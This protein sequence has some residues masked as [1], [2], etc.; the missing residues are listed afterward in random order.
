[1][2]VTTCKNGHRYDPSLTPEC[3][4]CAMIEDALPPEELD[5]DAETW[6]PEPEGYP[7]FPDGSPLPGERIPGRNLAGWL[8]CVGGHQ[9]GTDLR[10]YYDNNFVGRGSGN[11]VCIP[12][13]PELAR[14]KHCV[15][16]YDWVDGI[17]YIGQA[18]GR[19]MIRLNGKPV[20]SA[21]EL[22]RGDLLQLGGGI[23]RF[24][25]FCDEGF[26]WDWPPVQLE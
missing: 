25:P 10:L 19:S 20:L 2:N 23:Y 9:K 6:D 13:D 11:E 12:M 3:P 4:A 7:R 16:T 1:M 21:R 26:R 8:V 24:V 17:F 15:I 22:K 5:L 18:Q 14:E